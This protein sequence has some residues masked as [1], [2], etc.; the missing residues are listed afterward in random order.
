VKQALAIDKNTGTTFW[1]DAIDKEMKNVSIAFEFIDDDV[2]PIG[3]QQIDCHM[4]FDIKTDLTRKARL[5]A[6]GHQTDDS[7]ESCYSS[8]VLRDSVRIAFTIAALNDLDVMSAD[9][10][11]AYLNAKTKEKC[12][13]TCDLEFGPKNQ[14]QPV[15]IVRALYGLRSSGARFRD[16]MADTLCAGGFDPDVWMRPNTKWCG[17][18]YREYVLCYV[19]DVLAISHE[20]QK[21]MGYLNSVYTLKAGSVGRPT[22][23]LGCEV[24]QY[25]VHAASGSL[26]CW[27]LSSDTYVKRE[28]AEMERKLESTDQ[29]LR[30]KT[31]T[32]VSPTYRPELDVTPELEGEKITYYQGLSGVLRWMVEIGRVDTMM[33]VT[34]LSRFLANPREGHLE[35]V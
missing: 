24:K 21:I 20:P 25:N 17:F 3:F 30:K 22:T 29:K 34:L 6:G 26:D 15:K 5:V 1:R 27:A 31:S 10:Q 28:I 14:R 2:V 35:Q 18:K 4:I 9:V 7:D 19:D 11:N 8:V 13:T 16:H 32:P 12:Y 23:Y 33:P